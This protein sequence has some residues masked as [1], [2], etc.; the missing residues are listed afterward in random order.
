MS[1]VNDVLISS[2]QFLFK[3]L[4][5]QISNYKMLIKRKKLKNIKKI[6]NRNFIKFYL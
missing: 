1:Q 2:N 6:H 5:E 3:D 4:L